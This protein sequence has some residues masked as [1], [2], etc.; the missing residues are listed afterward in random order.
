METL[1]AHKEGY[2][3]TVIRGRHGLRTV[4]RGRH[5]LRTGRRAHL[6]RGLHGGV[7][8]HQLARAAVQRLE[9][10]QRLHA[11]RVVGPGGVLAGEQREREALQA[12]QQLAEHAAVECR[13]DGRVARAE[14]SLHHHPPTQQHIAMKKLRIVIRFGTARQKKVLERWTNPKPLQTSWDRVAI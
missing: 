13:G 5:G 1:K 12:R 11:D 10:V 4:I 2:L 8:L 3:S 7:A 9:A 14:C 6:R